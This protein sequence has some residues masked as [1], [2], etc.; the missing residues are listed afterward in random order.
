MMSI[1]FYVCWCKLL[2]PK[3]WGLVRV[4]Q[5]PKDSGDRTFLADVIHFHIICMVVGL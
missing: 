4:Y 2:D 1:L 5:R 3:A